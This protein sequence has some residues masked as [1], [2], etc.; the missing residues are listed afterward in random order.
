MYILT[1][2][3]LSLE[4][5]QRVADT[6]PQVVDKLDTLGMKSPIVRLRDQTHYSTVANQIAAKGLY[7]AHSVDVETEKPVIILIAPQG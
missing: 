6:L 3:T 4:I 5:I 7:L 2:F 1:V